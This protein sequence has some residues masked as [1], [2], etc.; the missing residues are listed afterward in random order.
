MKNKV[1]NEIS[2]ENGLIKSQK[3]GEK[4][5]GLGLKNVRDAVER[6]KG[7][8]DINVKNQQFIA[9]VVLPLD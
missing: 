9:R 2:I 7:I 6:S 1:S 5:H 8:F 4:N 3:A